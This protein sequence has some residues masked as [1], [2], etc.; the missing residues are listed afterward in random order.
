MAVSREI[1]SIMAGIE[2]LAEPQAKAQ[3]PLPGKSDTARLE[4]ML[5][6]VS[7]T[8]LPRRLVFRAGE[9]RRLVLTARSG[10][11]FAVEGITQ[12]D[13]EGVAAAL[14]AHAHDEGPHGYEVQ[15][16]GADDS[17]VG[18]GYPSGELRAACAAA[19]QAPEATVP[20]DFGARLAALST[21]SGTLKETGQIA[22]R[23]GDAASLPRSTGAAL[24]ADVAD[25]RGALDRLGGGFG[26]VLVGA[27]ED[28]APRLAL[29]EAEG[30]LWI[31]AARPGTAAQLLRAWAEARRSG[32]G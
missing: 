3:R 9:G 32:R 11:L 7:G 14:A 26:I 30:A 4:A 23:A 18:V 27:A 20:A 6:V 16:A 13:L 29:A 17:G 28:G 8:I 22:D 19:L 12:T 10:R 1:M 15:I 21:A 25:I 2:V 24:V 5:R 31:A